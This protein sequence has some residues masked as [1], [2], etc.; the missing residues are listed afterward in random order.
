MASDVSFPLKPLLCQ[1]WKPSLSLFYRTQSRL[2]TRHLL[3]SRLTSDEPS[4][5]SMNLILRRLNHINS[6][7]SNHCC[8]VSACSIHLSSVVRSSDVKVGPETT[9]SMTVI[10]KF[11][12]MCCTII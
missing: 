12:G 8:S 2:P 11:A 9:T 10:S 6:V 1:I 5:N 7:S 4:T 3:T